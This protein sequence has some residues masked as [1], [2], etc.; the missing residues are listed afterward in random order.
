M[1]S[2]ALDTVLIVVLCGIVA[3]YFVFRPSPPQL[4]PEPSQQQAAEMA[5][6]ERLKDPESAR[7]SEHRLGRNNA[8]CGV[9]NAKNAFGGYVGAR[10]YVVVTAVS[11][12][13]Y[14][15]DGAD[16][17]LFESAWEKHCS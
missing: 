8:S 17:S 11:T 1:N 14:I 13:V 2:R 7:F 9:V 10:R 5:V 12:W 15:D 4:Q 6:R 3:S 16:R